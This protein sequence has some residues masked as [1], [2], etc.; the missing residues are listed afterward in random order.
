MLLD[1][2]RYDELVQ[3]CDLAIKAVRPSA[4]I[5]ELR[6]MAKDE[7]GNYAGAIA[8]YTLALSVQAPIACA[9]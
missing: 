4:E 2:K 8:D 7:L 5:F 1:L 6:G 3:S 9:F